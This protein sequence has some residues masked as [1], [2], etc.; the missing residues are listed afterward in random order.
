M[1]SV[2]EALEGRPVTDKYLSVTGDVREPVMLRVPIGTYFRECVAL[3]GT[4]LSEYAAVNGGP[5]MGLV[6]SEKEKIDAA[7]VTKTTG[8]ILVLPPDH[9][10]VE[11]SKLKM[12]RIRLQSRSACIQCRYCTDLCPRLS[13]IHISS[14]Q[15]VIC[16]DD[17]FEEVKAEMERQGCCFLDDG[18]RAKLGKYILRAN[19]TMNAEIV[20]KSAQVIAKLADITIPA[21]T[22]IIVAPEDGVGYGHPYSNEKLARCV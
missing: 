3:A 11:R 16:T 8:N 20:G 10:L 17:Y 1:R 6:L 22:R 18:E 7:V 4:G 12:Q 13:L 5:M 19:G 21:G 15:S 14:E 9:Y 2:Y